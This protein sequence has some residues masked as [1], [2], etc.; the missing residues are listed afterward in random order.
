MESDQ[1]QIVYNSYMNSLKR[2]ALLVLKSLVVIVFASASF[3]LILLVVVSIISSDISY[4]SPIDFLGIGYVF[5]SLV[6]SKITSLIAWIFLIIIFA[7]V[8]YFLARYD[9]YIKP[10]KRQVNSK[11]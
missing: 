10:R 7:V 3:H 11:K 4:I 6:D 9:Y 8:L 1:K 2:I 5:P